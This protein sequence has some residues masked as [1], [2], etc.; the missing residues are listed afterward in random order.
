MHFEYLFDPR[1]DSS[2]LYISFIVDCR[3]W[4][5]IYYLGLEVVEFRGSYMVDDL[6]GSQFSKLTNVDQLKM[7]YV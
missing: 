1:D 7:Y 4:R 5:F 2:S 3:S 6:D